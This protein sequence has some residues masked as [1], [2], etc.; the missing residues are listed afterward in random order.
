MFL[1]II[2]SHLSLTVALCLLLCGVWNYLMKKYVFFVHVCAKVAKGSVQKRL[3]GRQKAVRWIQTYSLE[4]VKQLA[5][6][7]LGLGGGQEKQTHCLPIE[8]HLPHTHT[9]TN[10]SDACNDYSWFIVKLL[11]VVITLSKAD[12]YPCAVF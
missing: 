4:I 3:H 9:H 8:R 1:K 11:P 6:I 5:D 10:S 7:D 2:T 12:H